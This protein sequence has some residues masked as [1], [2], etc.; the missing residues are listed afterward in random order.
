MGILLPA[1]SQWVFLR[2]LEPHG[3]QL[4]DWRPGKLEKFSSADYFL[5]GRICQNLK[6]SEIAEVLQEINR[7][8]RCRT[9]E[10]RV[11]Q[12]GRTQPR[13]E[14]EGNTES[15]AMVPITTT[16]DIA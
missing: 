8:A 12:N 4:T 6:G 13:V 5:L 9:A 10:P 1:V 3:V 15:H 16:I 11:V 2:K 14:P 7:P